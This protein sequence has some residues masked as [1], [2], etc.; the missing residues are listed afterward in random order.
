ME[1]NSQQNNQQK[2]TKFKKSDFTKPKI[3]LS[4]PKKIL[5]IVGIVIVALFVIGG[6][7]NCNNSN[8]EQKHESSYI[9]EKLNWPSDGVAKLLPKPKSENG[10]IS[11]SS[12]KYFNC[13]VAK[14]CQDDFNDYINECK[15]KGFN[16]ESDYSSSRYESKDQNNNKLSIHWS[17]YNN[18]M[19]ITIGTKAYY[20][21]IDAKNKADKE[22]KE[23]EK[24]NEASNSSS[25]S[26]SVSSDLKSFLDSY[27]QFVDKYVAFMK[28]YKEQGNP[29]SMLA[30]YTE[31]M[32]QM[33]DFTSKMSTWE[34]KKGSMSA[35]DL[36]YYT[37]VVARC[38]QKLAQV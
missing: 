9:N 6:V 22:K 38:A 2:S 34:S 31:L 10:H 32:A 13:D 17:S 12:D 11:S 1:Q 19:S 15:T 20:D 4:K 24:Q 25:S 23:R 16:L 37:Q 7:S 28:K 27:E 30:E 26:G 3:K 21:E 18:E 8:K 35:K 5:L 29:I 14:T 36:E 33:S